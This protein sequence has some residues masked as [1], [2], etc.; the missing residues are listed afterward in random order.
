MSDDTSSLFMWRLVKSV[1]H[2]ASQVFT[3]KRL[4]CSHP[5]CY[6]AP[7]PW[8]YND[9]HLVIASRW[10]ISGVMTPGAGK[11]VV[12][13]CTCHTDHQIHEKSATAEI[14]HSLLLCVSA[15][16]KP[17]SSAVSLSGKVRRETTQ[18]CHWLRPPNPSPTS[19]QREW[20]R[21]PPCQESRWAN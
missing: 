17:K 8:R 11:L 9:C 10:T 20:P 15:I 12:D 16:N 6:S 5:A 2:T 3:P 19:S 14:K 1:Q 7:L 18:W 21:P 13:Q 4:Q